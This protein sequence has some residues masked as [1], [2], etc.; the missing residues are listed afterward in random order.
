[1]C[2]CPFSPSQRKRES[3]ALHLPLTFKSPGWSDGGYKDSSPSHVVTQRTVQDEQMAHGGTM[4]AFEALASSLTS[5]DWQRFLTL[6]STHSTLPGCW[7]SSDLDVLT[8]SI[9]AE[10]LKGQWV[11]GF[12]SS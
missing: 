3:L 5:P 4:P 10:L 2:V 1:L 12:L 11:D 9:P 7:V 6:S 8:D